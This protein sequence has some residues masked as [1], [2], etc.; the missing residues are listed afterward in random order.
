MRTNTM[1]LDVAPNDISYELTPLKFKNECDREYKGEISLPTGLKSIRRQLI[2]GRLEKRKFSK[3]LNFMENSVPNSKYIPACGFDC[4]CASPTSLSQASPIRWCSMPVTLPA[5]DWTHILQTIDAHMKFIRDS[6]K[7]YHLPSGLQLSIV[8]NPLDLEPAIQSLRNSMQ[9]DIISIDLEWKPDFRPDSNNKIALIQLATSTSC[10]LIRACNLGKTMPSALLKFFRDPAVTF[11][12]FS[13]DSSDEGK[14][15]NT[16]GI[17]R[18]S[19]FARYID[20]QTVAES[21]GYHG[22][23]L[24]TLTERV[25][26]V[27]P[28]KSKSTSRSDWQRSVLTPSQVQYAALDALLTG[29]VFRSLRLWHSSPS[30]C[31]SCKQNFGD[32]I[33]MVQWSLMICN[34]EKEEGGA[35]EKVSF[36]VYL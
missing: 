32:S 11:I 35:F 19:C 33:S 24:S 25:L 31:V 16:Y 6:N 9:D 8:D 17:G 28:P 14:M 2:E 30:P 23:G 26:G 18:R 3:Q 27:E 34:E 36:G 29:H 10:V 15:I 5:I 4:E 22:Y 13:W 21:L 12:S 7:T 20:L 1:D